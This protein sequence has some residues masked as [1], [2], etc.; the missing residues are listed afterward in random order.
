MRKERN[1]FACDPELLVDSPPI[2]RVAAANRGSVTSVTRKNRPSMKSGE[3][4]TF[5]RTANAKASPI[6]A[7]LASASVEAASRDRS[8]S[9]T[10][11]SQ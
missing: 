10:A 4:A 3:S 5:H 1:R 11:S 2:M 9:D 7:R 8:A 6:S